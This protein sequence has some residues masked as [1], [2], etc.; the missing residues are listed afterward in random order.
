MTNRYQQAALFQ[1]MVHLSKHPFDTARVI[2]AEQFRPTDKE[3]NVEQRNT[4][5]HSNA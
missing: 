3:I 1:R 4:T 5:E 2:S